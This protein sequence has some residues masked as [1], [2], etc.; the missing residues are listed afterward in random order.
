MTSSTDAEA[1]GLPSDS[2][3]FTVA[4]SLK[5]Q[6]HLVWCG[7]SLLRKCFPT[8][9]KLDVKP[10]DFDAILVG[11]LTAGSQEFPHPTWAPNL[12]PPFPPQAAA[13]RSVNILASIAVMATEVIY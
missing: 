9:A 10:S 2:P 13:N 8:V 11:T 7:G 3:T 6:T 1:E 4:D 12:P 5:S